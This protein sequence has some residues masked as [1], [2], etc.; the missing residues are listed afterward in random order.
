MPLVLVETIAPGRAH[1]G[2]A[3]QRRALDVEILGHGLDDPV[4]LRQRRP[5]SSSKLPAVMSALAAVGE[6]GH[7][8]LFGGI[9]DARER[10][11]VALG[12]IG[13]HDIQEVHGKPGVGEVGGDARAHG[14]GPEDPNTA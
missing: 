6:E 14:A 4:A 10:R 13:N 8:P 3:S 2:N 9:L 5:R 12:L 1:G 11:G 7:G